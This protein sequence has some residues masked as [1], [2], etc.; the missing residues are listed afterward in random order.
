[1][2]TGFKAGIGLV[3]LLDQAPKL[4][5]L[6]IAKHGSSPTWSSLVRH[7]P[8]TSLPT[9]AVGAPPRWSCWSGWSASSRIRRPRWSSSPA[10][11]PASWLLDLRRTGVSIVGH[12]PQGLPSLTLPD[13]R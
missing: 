2:L 8:E 3:I 4:L 6:H 7:L 13:P 9:L 10:R 12:I 1:M 11:I 5:G